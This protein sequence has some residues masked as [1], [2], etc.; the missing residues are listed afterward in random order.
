VQVVLLV[1][2]RRKEVRRALPAPP[3]KQVPVPMACVNNAKL[4]NSEQLRMQLLQPVRFVQLVTIKTA[5][6]KSIV[7]PV[8]QACTKGQMGRNHVWIVQS[9]NFLVAAPLLSGCKALGQVTQV[10]WLD[11]KIRKMIAEYLSR[12]RVQQQTVQQQTVR[13]TRAAPG[14]VMPNLE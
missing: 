2:H 3:V 11:L 12:P 6:D 14:N 1:H 4:A 9:V 8:P 13:H 10:Q 7:S 5:L